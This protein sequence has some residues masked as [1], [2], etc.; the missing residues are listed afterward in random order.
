MAVRRGV[1]LAGGRG[2]RLGMLTNDCPK[3]MLPVGDRPFLD[4]LIRH[5]AGQ[6]LTDILVLAGWQGERLHA[7]YENRHIAG[8]TV[9]VVV[10]PEAMGTGGALRFAA[11]RLAPPV[12]LVNGD[13]LFDAD[14]QALAAHPGDWSLAMALRHLE[15]TGRSGRVVLEG[16]RVTGFQERGDG[17]PGLVNGGVYVV[18][19][20]LLEAIAGPCSLERDV[21]PGQAAAGRLVGRVFE[22]MFI[23]IGVPADLARAQTVVPAFMGDDA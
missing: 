15:D 5:L 10:E 22:G 9:S 8:A 3:P 2:T 17:G 16:D 7:A 11:D 1:I 19:P 23:D 12:A 18:R 20:G 14:V 4:H 21:F 13:T 6:G